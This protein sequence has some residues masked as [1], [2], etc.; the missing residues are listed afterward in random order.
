MI[1]AHQ[2]DLDGMATSGVALSIGDV[3]LG[4]SEVAQRDSTL[5]ARVHI[6]CDYP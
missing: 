1:I 3:L 6:T 2:V 4:H 5:F